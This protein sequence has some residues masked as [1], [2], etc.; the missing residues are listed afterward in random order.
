MGLT[1]VAKGLEADEAAHWRDVLEENGIAATLEPGTD[2]LV[3]A[4][5]ADAARALFADPFAEEGDESPGEAAVEVPVLAPGERTEL[6]ARTPDF[7]A[8]QRL[9]SILHAAGIYAAV[10]SSALVNTFGA[11]GLPETTITIASSQR[12]AAFVEL[13]AVARDQLETFAGAQHIDPAEVL[14][15][16]LVAPA[17]LVRVK[18]NEKE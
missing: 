11:D 8:A 15:A 3:D 1:T 7:A 16:L 10:R 13:S 5:H 18:P 12:E 6:L 17:G 2:V 14:E 4:E 9:A